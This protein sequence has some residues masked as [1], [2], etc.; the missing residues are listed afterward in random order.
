MGLSRQ[1]YWRGVP[2]P[3]PGDLPNPGIEPE[4][5]ALAGGFF[6]TEPPRKPHSHIKIRWLNYYTFIRQTIRLIK[7]L[8]MN[9]YIMTRTHSITLTK[10]A[11]NAVLAIRPK[12]LKVFMH[13][14]WN[15]NRNSLCIMGL[16]DF[17][18][19]FYTFRFFSKCSI[20][21]MHYFYN[22][23]ETLN[24]I[25]QVGKKAHTLKMDLESFSD[26]SLLNFFKCHH[27]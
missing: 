17:Y 27:Y 25:K 19:L 1:E 21:K 15:I 5:P 6:T 16:G 13:I 23:K 20:I 4:S 9:K 7:N 2:F 11:F 26:I 22:Q 8:P 14:C 18:F 10:T 12:S 24:I 3:S